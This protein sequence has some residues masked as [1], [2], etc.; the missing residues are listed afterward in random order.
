MRSV[1]AWMNW[2]IVVAAVSLSPIVLIFGIP[3]AVGAGLDIFQRFGEMPLTLVLAAPV[4]FA[5]VR[6]VSLHTPPHWL[7]AAAARLPM[8][9]R[10]A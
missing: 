8:P 7:A 9:H 2:G 4:A 5:L 3:L 1:T 6:Q 10:H